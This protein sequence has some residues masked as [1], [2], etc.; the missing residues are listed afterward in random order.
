MDSRIE[1]RFE[2]VARS[3][4]FRNILNAY[5]LSRRAVLDIGCTYGE[6]LKHFGPGSV[7]L[8]V[9]K[10][11]VDIGRSRGLNIQLA[12]IENPNF[13]LEEKFNV[14]FANNIFE[15]MQSPHNFLI[16]IKRFLKPG[17]IIV[18]GVPCIPYFSFLMRLN[19]FR[20]ALASP[21]INFF[22]RTTLMKTV[23]YAG[24]D[25]LEVRGFRFQSRMIDYLI[26]P[27]YPHFYVIAKMDP[28]FRYSDKRLRELAGYN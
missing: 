13:S 17:G 5:G 19:K 27:I 2:N 22:T 6:F 21:H 20:G 28:D 23:E 25:I 18:L 8:T 11:E 7:G 12:N 14:I 4:T 24:W 16:R 26:N 1:M 15:H 9:I 3:K 10:E